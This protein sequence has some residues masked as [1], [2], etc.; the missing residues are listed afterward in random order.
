MATREDDLDLLLSLR[1]DRVLETPPASP[2]ANPLVPSDDG[3]PERSRDAGM[4]VFRDAVKDYLD[5]DASTSA[6]ATKSKKAKRSDEVVVEK[7][8]GLRIRNPLV[9]SVEIGNRFSDIRFI[10]LPAIKNLLSGDGLSG[11]WATVGVVLEKGIPRV[12]STGKSYGIWKM[13]CL[14]ESDVSVF[15]FGDS[16][17]RCCEEP[18]GTVFALFNSA[19]RKDAGSKGFSLSVYSANQM[20]KIGASIDYGLCRGKRKDGLACTMVINKRQGTFCKFHT[21]KA[22]QRYSTGRAELKGGN[23]H[24]AFKLQSEGIYMV[25]PLSEPSCLRKPLQRVKVMS[26]DGL[27][28]ALRCISN[29]ADKVTTNSQSQGVRF[30]A[31]VTAKMESKIQ[32]KDFAKKHQVKCGSEKRS[33]PSVTK[34]AQNKDPESKRKRTKNPSEN[35]IEL[36]IVS[37]DE[38]SQC[39]I[40]TL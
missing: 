5:A 26:V 28:K 37:S 13:G 10:R 22:A 31:Q 30:L 11:C 2:S 34:V 1:D 17:T 36:D 38:E 6:G 19:V 39:Y 15:L 18:V 40:A 16:Y 21:S 20:L 23:L 24:T 14:D 8:S 4:S 29:N 25:E 32:N 7:F 33:S 9:S 3:S 35:T 12:S 27:R